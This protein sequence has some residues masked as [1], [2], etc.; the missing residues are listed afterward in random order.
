MPS[1][2]RYPIWV[3]DPTAAV[4]TAARYAT[5]GKWFTSV[6]EEATSPVYGDYEM[7]TCP[8]AK[9]AAQHLVNLPTHLRVS[10]QDV[11]VISSSMVGMATTGRR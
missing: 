4:L 3:E 2:V 8:R 6:L 9:E 11:E 7:G 5:L 10:M 1:Y